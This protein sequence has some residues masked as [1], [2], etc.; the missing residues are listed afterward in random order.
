MPNDTREPQ[1]YGSQA[2]WQTGNTG[3]QVNKP[4]PTADPE[5]PHLGGLVSDEQLADNVQP[6]GAAEGASTPVQK[7]TSREGGAKRDSYFKKRDYE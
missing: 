5:D 4:A 3:Q 1:S 2:D 6:E 7:V